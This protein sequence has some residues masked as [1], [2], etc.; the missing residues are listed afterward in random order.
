MDLMIEKMGA[1]RGPPQKGSGGGPG[2]GPG[3]GVLLQ[4]RGRNSSA[5]RSRMQTKILS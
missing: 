4:V 5:N 1:L 2:D 3:F